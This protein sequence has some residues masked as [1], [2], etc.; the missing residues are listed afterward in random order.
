MS[1]DLKFLIK[2]II[3]LGGV[4]IFAYFSSIHFG[5]LYENLIASLSGSFVELR[6][7][8][9]LPLS[10]IF[11]LTLLFTTFGGNKKYWWIGALLFPAI[12]FEIYFDFSHI[13][14]PT[15]IGVTGWLSGFLLMKM[16][17]RT[18]IV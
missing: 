17:N 16:I 8:F 12:A 9:G 3:I 11:F 2:N 1:D 14:F 4:L 15:A 13:Y 7:V 5:N 10:Y 18:K 6:S